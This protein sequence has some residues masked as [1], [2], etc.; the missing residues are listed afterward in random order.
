MN[1]LKRFYAIIICIL[2]VSC[3]SSIETSQDVFRFRESVK[4]PAPDHFEKAYRIIDTSKLYQLIA[5]YYLYDTA[6]VNIVEKY[7]QKE[8]L[9][10][11]SRGRLA[12]YDDFDINTIDTLKPKVSDQGYYSFKYGAIAT[13]HYIT[14]EDGK[15]FYNPQTL[16]VKIDTIIL[17]SQSTKY[18]SKYLPKLIPNHI[19]VNKANW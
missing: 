18:V 10:F 15:Q 1:F 2:L 17:Y 11:Y 4:N 14:N 6:Q 19:I 16:D 9:K 5:S 13:M 7:N 8:Y 3:S 12:V